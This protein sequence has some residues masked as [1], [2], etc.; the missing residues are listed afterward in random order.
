MLIVSCFIG[1]VDSVFATFGILGDYNLSC[2]WF[3]SFDDLSTSSSFFEDGK[4]IDIVVCYTL[5]PILP[6]DL[7][8]K[9]NLMNRATIQGMSG[10]SIF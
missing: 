7:M 3:I 2:G 6:I 10:S 5:D 8:P 9:M 1:K 4:T